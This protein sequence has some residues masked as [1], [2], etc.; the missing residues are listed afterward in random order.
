MACSGKELKAAL[1]SLLGFWFVGLF[2]SIGIKPAA[3]DM[4]AASLSQSRILQTCAM[5]HPNVV[6][7][8]GGLQG[9]ST[10]FCAILSLLFEIDWGNFAFQRSMIIFHVLNRCTQCPLFLHSSAHHSK[11][12]RELGLFFIR[13]LCREVPLNWYIYGCEYC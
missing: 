1:Q 3:S 13:S 2:L 8:V 4:L 12:M 10:H 6:N 5:P 7:G 9:K 11:V